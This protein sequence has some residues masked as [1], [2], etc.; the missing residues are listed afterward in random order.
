ME[1]IDLAIKGTDVLIK[2]MDQLPLTFRDVYN[3]KYIGK[4]IVA[5]EW[6]CMGFIIW[7]WLIGGMGRIVWF[8]VVMVWYVT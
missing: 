6:F 4:P 3:G 7:E 8:F 1:M 2:G 5:L